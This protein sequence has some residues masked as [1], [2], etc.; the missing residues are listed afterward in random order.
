MVWL[1]EVQKILKNWR[2]QRG[3]APRKFGFLTHVL[4]IFQWAPGLDFWCIQFSSTDQFN[5]Q[6]C[7]FKVQFK[8][9]LGLLL[10]GLGNLANFL[11]ACPITKN[12]QP[13]PR[14]SSILTS[15]PGKL[16]LDISHR[17]PVRTHA[18]AE[19][20]FSSPCEFFLRFSPFT[21][22]PTQKKTSRQP[23]QPTQS[24]ATLFSNVKTENERK[25]EKE[26]AV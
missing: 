22:A 6:S 2:R 11:E 3:W 1:K 12:C 23:A 17:F 4:V 9:T 18:D 16:H 26:R 19:I 14:W 5:V 10:W 20:F 8:W 21:P 25:R 24:L 7:Q 15:S 13:C